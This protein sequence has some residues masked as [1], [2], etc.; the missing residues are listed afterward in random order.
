MSMQIQSSD[1]SF[2]YG[3]GIFSTIRICRGKPQLWSLHWSRLADSMQRLGFSVLNENV[4]LSQ[5]STA[6]SAQDQVLKVLISRGQGARGYGTLGISTPEVYCWTAPLPDYTAM[7]QQGVSLGL[8]NMR[9]SQQ[10]LLAGIKHCSRLETVLLKREA[11]QSQYDDLLICD[12]QGFLIEASAANL[13]V[14]HQQQWL[15]PDLQQAGVAGVMRQL[16]LQQQ[17]VS[18]QALPADR[19]REVSTMALCNALMGIVPVAAFAG[20]PL[21]T[22]PAVALQRQVDELLQ[23]V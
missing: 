12:Q 21:T 4:V 23:E 20:R 6:I 1:R 16:L 2:Q 7:R 14:W 11:E 22:Q 15:T 19:L 5:I 8:A 18:V 10:P 17:L 13:L 9:L 3:D